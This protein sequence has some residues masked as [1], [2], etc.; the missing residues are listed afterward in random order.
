MT[1]EKV[2]YK[3]AK[4][5]AK[6]EKARAKA[7][8]P[9]FKKKRFIFPIAL[10]L[11][12]GISTASNKGND[13]SDSASSNSNSSE[14]QA[15]ET[16]ESAALGLGDQAVDGKFT[17]TITGVKCGIKKVGD[18]YL[19]KKPQGQFCRVSLTVKNTGDEAQTMFADNQKLFDAQDREFSADTSA[20]IY[21]GEKANTWIEDVNPGNTLEGSL[22]FDL[23]KDATPVKIELHDDAFSGGVEV[24][25]K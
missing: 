15:P 23:P 16:T 5:D 17:F 25:L 1:E 22:L 14:S 19:N 21:D 18:K 20:M 9:W 2:D 4:A 6:A 12:I 3:S 24:S 10:V 11:I 13:N 7:L 8:R